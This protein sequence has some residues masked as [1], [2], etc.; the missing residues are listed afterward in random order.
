LQVLL[1]V[2]QSTQQLLCDP[3]FVFDVPG[4]QLPA[5][6]QHPAQVPLKHEL[7]ELPVLHMPPAASG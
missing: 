1:S 6:S 7:P 4:W 5:G 3:Q 2:L